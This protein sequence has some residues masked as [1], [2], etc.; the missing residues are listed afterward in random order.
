MKK[1]VSVI[2]SIVLCFSALPIF[3][4]A[5]NRN[6][7]PDYPVV[8]LRGTG[9]EL[10]DSQGNKVWKLNLDT[11]T[12]AKHVANV[13]FPHLLTAVAT[14]N[15]NPW[16]NAFEKELSEVFV[17]VKCDD[18]GNTMNGVSINPEYKKLMDTTFSNAKLS[19]NNGLRTN[20]LNA[21]NFYYD[22]R[23]D[24]YIEADNL[25][26]RIK[27][28]EKAFG[29]DKVNLFASCAGGTVVLA[30]I[31]KYGNADLNTVMLD[32]AVVRG[33]IQASAFFNGRIKIDG[34]GLERYVID[35]IDEN[36]SSKQEMMNVLMATLKQLVFL[37]NAS[38]KIDNIDKVFQMFYKKVNGELMPK[39]LMSFVGTWIHFWDSIRPEDYES[40]KNYV[41]CT[42]AL[43]KKYSKLIEK[44]DYYQKNVASRVDELLLD[45]QASGTPVGFA[46]KYGAQCMPLLS[47]SNELSDDTVAVKDLALGATVASDISTTLPKDYIQSQKA[48]GLGEYISPDGQIDASTCVFPEKT[49]FIKGYRHVRVDPYEE[50]KRE[51]FLTNGKLCVNDRPEFS[52]FMMRD[53]RTDKMVL[54]TEEN[55]RYANEYVSGEKIEKGFSQYISRFLSFVKSLFTLVKTLLKTYVFKK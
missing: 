20:M 51:F 11:K 21:R 15:W 3:A 32:S 26:A 2:L 49:W 5:T 54:M 6:Q 27:Q 52:R 16:I 41:F 50:M 7:K 48:N 24:P 37:M 45:C 53:S 14:G 23:I 40:A 25:H 35:N 19:S 43:R 13:V 18:E 30:Y 46:V 39:L 55:Y 36:D 17:G 1:T 4:S 44:A 9:E 38:G 22:F 29:V 42:D 8:Y 34:D 33:S 47:T 28:L 12:I 31:E 10:F